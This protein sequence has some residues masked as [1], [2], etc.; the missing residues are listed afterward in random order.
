MIEAILEA[1][2]GIGEWIVRQ[3]HD[4]IRHATSAIALG[5]EAAVLTLILAIS[6]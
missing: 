4:A 3:I 2:W 5:A 6:A 1:M